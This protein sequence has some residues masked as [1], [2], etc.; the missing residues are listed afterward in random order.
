MTGAPRAHHNSIMGDPLC[1]GAGL[2]S[3][4]VTEAKV[5]LMPFLYLTAG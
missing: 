2:Y 4:Y 1:Q 3:L 5:L